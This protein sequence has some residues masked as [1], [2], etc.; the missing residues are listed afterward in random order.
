[1]AKD[2]RDPVPDCEI[3]ERNCPSLETIQLLHP[4]EPVS[5][6]FKD[7]PQEEPKLQERWARREAWDLAKQAYK[8]S[9]VV[10]TEERQKIIEIRSP[11]LQ[12]EVGGVRVT[13]E[14]SA[15]HDV[16]VRPVACA[17]TFGREREMCMR[18]V[19]EKK[20]L[21]VAPGCV[22]CQAKSA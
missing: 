22:A 6:K 16:A 8:I 4:H 20:L 17:R 12:F 11:L 14:A 2:L 5:P 15:T 3:R 9:S 21:R 18:R 7:R 19:M 10:H 1:M 13:Q